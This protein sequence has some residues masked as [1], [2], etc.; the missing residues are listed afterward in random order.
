M[1]DRNDGQ[2]ANAESEDSNSASELEAAHDFRQQQQKRF[3]ADDLSHYE[4]LNEKF[5]EALAFIRQ[6]FPGV[7]LPGLEANLRATYALVSDEHEEPISKSSMDEACQVVEDMVNKLG[8]PMHSGVSY[9]VLHGD[10]LQAMQQSLMMT[11]ASVILMTRHLR[12]AIHRL[13]KLVARSLPSEGTADDKYVVWRFEEIK[14]LILSDEQLQ[15]D[16]AFFLMDYSLDPYSPAIGRA[17]PVDGH[18][19]M[20]LMGD[21]SEALEWFV[22]AHEYGHHIMRHTVNGAC[23]AG[24]EDIVISQRKE[25][26]ADSIATHICIALGEHNARG[27]NYSAYCNAGSVLVLSALDCFKRGRKL[28]LTG[29]DDGYRTDGGHPPLEQRLDTIAAVTRE[30]Y[31]MERGEEDE[32][33]KAIL[34]IQD[35]AHELIEFI[36]SESRAWMLREYTLGGVRGVPVQDQF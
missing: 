5:D 11:K 36:W 13:A 8:F 18:D 24:G 20:M 7:E 1:D 28:M 29:T 6:Q 16:W 9:G 33:L 12:T 35:T 27:L 17:I 14:S 32:H 21:L 23:G 10:G 26:E 4:S 30:L 2:G 34:S 22:L 19:Q 25:I 31:L 3:G 15:K